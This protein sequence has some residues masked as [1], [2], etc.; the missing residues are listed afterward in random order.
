MHSPQCLEPD[1]VLSQANRSSQVFQADLLKRTCACDHI[2]CSLRE[3]FYLVKF[4]LPIESRLTLSITDRIIAGYANVEVVDTQGE[5]I[6][7]EAWPEAFRKFMANP[8]FRLVHVFHTDIPVGEVVPQYRDS[9]G[10][11][12][13]SHADNK[14]LFVV[15]RIRRD[16]IAADR[17]WKAIETGELRAF[18]ISGLALER[19]TEC[20]G[21][22]CFKVIPRLELHS[23]TICEK[24]SNPPAGFVIVKALPL[25][26]VKN[27]EEDRQSRMKMSTTKESLGLGD[28]LGFQEGENSAQTPAP[29]QPAPDATKTQAPPAP[30]EKVTKQN[31]PQ[32]M[33]PILLEMKGGIEKLMGICEKI[34]TEME[35]ARKPGYPK[36]E[37]KEGMGEDLEE[38]ARRPQK[39]PYPKKGEKPEG[40]EDEEKAGQKP[41]EYPYPGKKKAKEGE[42]EEEEDEEEKARK[43][44]PYPPPA[45]KGEVLAITA[46]DLAKMIDEKVTETLQKTL[47]GKTEKRGIVTDIGAPPTGTSLQDLAKMPLAKLGSMPK[48]EWLRMIQ[49][50]A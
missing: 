27:L 33:T 23:I 29:T 14:G 3:S 6:P 17:V 49:G 5:L 24:G 39:F 40:E 38:K 45:R 50:G 22:R 18:S 1:I 2:S 11:V 35:K 9:K 41:E 34:M 46:E 30:S 8:K 28:D 15:V 44:P 12:W 25:E 7:A 42:E 10:R 16:L 47:G 4:A 21:G 37:E 19:R 36:P 43:K 13:K 20:V 32:D 31:P 26:R 48:Q